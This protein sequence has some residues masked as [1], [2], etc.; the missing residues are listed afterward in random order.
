MWELTD[1]VQT[2]SIPVI[3]RTID[4]LSGLIAGFDYL[5]NNGVAKSP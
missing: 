4:C 5:Y 3:H 2:S 1:L